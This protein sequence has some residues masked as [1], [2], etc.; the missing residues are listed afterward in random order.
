MKNS[1]KPLLLFFL[2][3]FIPF[4]KVISSDVEF[5]LYPN[6]FS[7]GEHAKLEVRARG[8]KPFRALQTNIKQ[9]GVRIQF[10]GS[11]TETQIIN[12]KVSKSQIL[13]FYVSTEAEGS[14]KLPE[15]S[16]EYDHKTYSSP[17]ISFKV[18]KKSKQSQNQWF[19]PFPFEM[20][21]DVTPESP[22]VSFHTNKSVFYKGEPIVGYFVLYYN[23]Y[24]Q[25][26]LER[27]P[28]QSI[29]Y[30]YFLS[31]TLKQVSVQIEPEVLRN[32][33]LKKTLV[34]DKEIYGLT[35]IKAGRFQIGKT[36]FI[37]GDSLRFNSL[38]ETVNTNPATVT[39][40][41]LPPGKPKEFTG[42]IGNFKLNLTEFPKTV[43][44]G[45][46]LYYEVTVEGEGGY[47]GITPFSIPN[48]KVQVISQKRTKT[49]KKLD[50]GEY[51]FYSVVKFLFGHQTDLPGKL[52][53]EPYR[54]SFF[55]LNEKQ[56]K[57]L[58]LTF[59][60]ISVL[61]E[62][63]KSLEAKKSDSKSE[64]GPSIIVLVL[65]AVFGILSYVGYKRYSI[66]RQS[67]MF[68]E[69]IQSFGK[70]RNVFLAD[71]LEKKGI[72]NDDNQFLVNLL[73]DSDKLTPEK[74]FKNLSNQEK[75][76]VLVLKKQLQNKE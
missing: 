68:S 54:F 64:S 25:P 40:L 55:S 50:S 53:L 16:V 31:E 14:F 7:L 62:K 2:I 57:S 48:S 44:R 75:T 52:Q 9:N 66:S 13:N 32:N 29:S 49:F 34:Y 60:E 69:M 51:G 6:E 76:K 24:R 27:D 47:E 21:E 36:K 37:T 43:H 70:K 59:P 33:Q 11:G 8:D 23:G 28:N 15:I 45:E 65:I 42:A 30:P 4:T 19:N 72:Q 56:Y 58:V 10:S 18:S 3:Y 74:T 17:P 41:E 63:K 71:Y 20:E 46:T 67:K 22:E 1:G 26:F 73:N 38:Q 35:G 61:P 12:F 39:V 5:N